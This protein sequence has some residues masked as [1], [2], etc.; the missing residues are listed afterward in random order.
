MNAQT[1]PQ[2]MKSLRDQ[3]DISMA[4]LFTVVRT[5]LLPLPHHLHLPNRH[6]LED[7]LNW[8]QTGQS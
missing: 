8:H 2:N 1:F 6:L 4:L 3:R 5:A 7:L